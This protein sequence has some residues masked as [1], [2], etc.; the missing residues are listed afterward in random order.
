M[1][2]CTTYWAVHGF[3]GLTLTLTSFLQASLR[4]S[5]LT[6]EKVRTQVD[7]IIW[8]DGKRIVLLAEVLS[9]FLGYKRMKYCVSMEHWTVDNLHALQSVCMTACASVFLQ[10]FLCQRVLV[11]NVYNFILVIIMRLNAIS[12][13]I[14]CKCAQIP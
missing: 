7:H 3:H 1:G 6:W 14:R 5:D 10:W 8:P 13:F 2:M 4:T 9:G 12:A 11:W